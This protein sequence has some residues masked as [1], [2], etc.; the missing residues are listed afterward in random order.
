M[1]PT[2]AQVF[3]DWDVAGCLWGSLHNKAS[4]HQA[5]LSKAGKCPSGLHESHEW[6]LW[7]ARII[8]VNESKDLHQRRW[9]LH[10]C[11]WKRWCGS[12]LYQMPD[13][14][15]RIITNLHSTTFLQWICKLTYKH[16]YF[17]MWAFFKRCRYTRKICLS[18][19]RNPIDLDGHWGQWLAILGRNT[20][21][22]FQSL[23]FISLWSQFKHTPVDR[24]HISPGCV[25][26]HQPGSCL[27]VHQ[28][29]DLIDYILCKRLQHLCSVSISGLCGLA[30]THIL[31]KLNH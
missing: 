10:L 4:V 22:A 16:I 12:G 19:F 30:H 1:Y 9:M 14:A 31:Q 7:Q 17:S 5:V 20:F 6:L 13:N 2:R 21:Q 8:N 11:V 18:I 24:C 28:V 29:Q 23:A 26:Q 27:Q 15:I 25:D 3:S